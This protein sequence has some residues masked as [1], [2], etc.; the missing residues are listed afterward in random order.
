M[1]LPALDQRAKRLIIWGRQTQ[2]RTLPGDVPVQCIDFRRPSSIQMLSHGWPMKLVRT[3]LLNGLHRIRI[4]EGDSFGPDERLRF[5]DDPGLKLVQFRH[6]LDVAR[7]QPRYRA[8][9][10]NAAVVHKLGPDGDNDI[11]DQNGVQAS[12][13]KKL[14]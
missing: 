4:I 5:L 13:A 10:V 6:L 8:D 3:V 11:L 7:T 1:V 9:R 14:T 12:P 2:A